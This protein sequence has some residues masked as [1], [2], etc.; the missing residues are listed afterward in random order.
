VA[1]VIITPTAQRNL[2]D[3]ITT[4][5]LPASTRERLRRSL[6]QLRLFPLIGAPLP[7]RVPGLRYVLGPWRWMIIV[8]R[9]YQDADEIRIISVQDARSAQSPTSQS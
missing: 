5:S 4:H 9:Y 8:Y 6:E 1:S 2:S 7:S 3:L